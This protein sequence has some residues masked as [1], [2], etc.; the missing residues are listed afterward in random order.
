MQTVPSLALHSCTAPHTPSITLKATPARSSSLTQSRNGRIGPKNGLDHSTRANAAPNGNTSSR[1][2]RKAAAHI[3]G[4]WAISAQRPIRSLTQNAPP[5][6][7]LVKGRKVPFACAPSV[8]HA[9]SSSHHRRLHHA[10]LQLHT[11]FAFHFC[12]LVL[13]TRAPAHGLTL[14][15][16]CLSKN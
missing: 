2:S 7:R 13:R 11:L 3:L 6:A 4:R 8:H 15:L 10:R 5:R 12:V 9:A 16:C 14:S 1:R